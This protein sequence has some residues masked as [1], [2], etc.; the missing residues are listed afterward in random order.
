MK[1]K[2]I[3]LGCGNSMGVPRIDSFWGKCN[4]KNKKNIRTRCSAVIIKGSNTVLIDTSP[5]IRSQLIK[6][7]VKNISSVVYSHEHAD[8]TNGL[9]ELRPFTFKSKKN[10]KNYPRRVIDLYGNKKTMY[11]LK[12]R[13]DYCF[14][15]SSIYPQIVKSNIVK[16]SFSLG[17]GNEK[18]NIN[19]LTVKHGLVKSTA[20]IFNKI[21]YIS[22]CNDLS[23]I[24]MNKLKN[25]K[26]LI[27]D[28]LK[29]VKNY[30]HFNLDECLFIYKHL[31]PKKMILT[32]LHTDLDYDYLSSILPKGVIPAYDGLKINL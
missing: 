22:D 26:Y 31:K 6:N 17:R 2:F 20:Y 32:N 24:K 21:A 1:N 16:K 3:I 30:A 18:I 13:F 10:Q 27:L 14:N 15:K 12:K 7:K 11:L 19:T 4:K 9:F 28:C 8:Q 23:I 25:L 5:D 29:I